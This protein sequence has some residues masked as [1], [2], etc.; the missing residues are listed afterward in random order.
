VSFDRE[1]L[2]TKDV[3]LH[4]LPLLLFITMLAFNVHVISVHD[5]AQVLCVSYS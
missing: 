3:I 1:L 4:E 2:N 5:E